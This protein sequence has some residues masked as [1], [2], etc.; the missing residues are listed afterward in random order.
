MGGTIRYSE[1]HEGRQTEIFKADFSFPTEDIFMISDHTMGK[2]RYFQYHDGNRIEIFVENS[3]SMSQKLTEEQFY[4][5]P[6]EGKYGKLTFGF[7]LV[8][9][10]DTLILGQY[11]YDR[12]VKRCYH[13]LTPYEALK[14]G[15]G[16]VSTMKSASSFAF[17][18]HGRPG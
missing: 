11:D 8:E 5:K 6:K 3:Q 17:Q 12:M 4:S 2:T 18:S 10:I 14:A 15:P 16:R 1:R 13:I 7:G 9:E